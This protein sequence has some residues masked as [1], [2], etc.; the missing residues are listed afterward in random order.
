LGAVVV[1]LLGLSLVGAESD[2]TKPVPAEVLRQ[3]LDQLAADAPYGRRGKNLGPFELNDLQ[4][5]NWT[6]RDLK[7]KTTIVVVWHTQCGFCRPWLPQVQE[8][9]ERFREDPRIRVVT[10]NI[11]EDLDLLTSYM[12][13]HPYTFPVLLARTFLGPFPIPC[14]WIVDQEGIVR[15][16]VVG[17]FPGVRELISEEAIALA[18][19][20]SRSER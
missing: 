6:E 12:K 13:E 1:G 2:G 20:A 9:H 10:L 11:N 8:L 7:G 16:E 3:H 15:V 4:G 19:S 14:T 18:T 17:Q 5:R